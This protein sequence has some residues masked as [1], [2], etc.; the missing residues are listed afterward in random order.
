[1]LDG[2]DDSEKLGE[3]LGEG[4]GGFES[5][6][7]VG[8]ELGR[9]EIVPERIGEILGTELDAKVGLKLKE[10]E[11]VGLLDG[12]NNEVEEILEEEDTVRFQSKIVFV[13]EWTFIICCENIQN[14]L[15][16]NLLLSVF[17]IWTTT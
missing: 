13:I 2:E 8:W 5:G 10:G 4:I 17:S 9:D 12:K 7:R 3:L 11:N 14:K 15:I 16:K 1:M 6:S